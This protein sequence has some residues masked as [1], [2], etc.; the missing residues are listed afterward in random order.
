M[1]LTYSKANSLLTYLNGQS[2]AVYI[3]LSTTAPARDGTGVHEP[4]GNGYS[5]KRLQDMGTPTNG[6]TTNTDTIYFAEATGDW[7]TC[8]YFCLFSGATGDN[9]IAYGALPGG[10]IHPTDG[11]VPLI[12]A[13]N[14]SLSM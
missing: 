6:I 9:L 14:L 1:A 7:G 3:G 8:T 11:K 4:E 13:G 5:R 2:G 12:R 10:G